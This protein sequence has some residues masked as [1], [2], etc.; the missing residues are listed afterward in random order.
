VEEGVQHGAH[1]AEPS[2]AADAFQRPLRSRFQARLSASVRCQV[3]EGKIQE[4]PSEFMYM[5]RAQIKYTVGYFFP[6]LVM[7]E[8]GWH[9][10]GS[11]YP[12]PLSLVLLQL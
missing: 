6:Y 7:A 3:R 12:R 10:H 4:R 11:R 2:T 9:A 8:G 1:P 5:L